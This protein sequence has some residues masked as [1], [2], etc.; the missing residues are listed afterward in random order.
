MIL[1]GIPSFQ[2]QGKERGK[3]DGIGET[4]CFGTEKPGKI[5]QELYDVQPKGG[6]IHRT[7]SK[8]RK[9]RITGGFPVGKRPVRMGSVRQSGSEEPDEMGGHVPY[10]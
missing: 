3:N 9:P 4:D 6:Q 7:G 1:P 10:L 2:P 5:Q 8:E